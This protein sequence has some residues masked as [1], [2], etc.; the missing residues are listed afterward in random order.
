MGIKITLAGDQ[1]S[2]KSTVAKLL[3]EKL[4]ATYYSTG[5]YARAYATRMNMDINT[6]GDYTRAHPEID[7]E[8]DATL[9]PL[10][11]DTENN[12]VIDSRMA[13]H[14][15]RG[16][17]TVFLF[18]DRVESARRIFTAGRST[19]HFPTLEDA[20]A[21]VKDRRENEIARYSGLYGVD[22]YDPCHYALMVDTTHATP[23]QVA[24]CIVEAQKVWQQNHDVQLRYVCPATLLYPDDEA[25]GERMAE[26]AL[27]VERGEPLPPV[28]VYQK[29]GN[30][31]VVGGVETALVGAMFNMTHVPFVFV[32]TM[33]DDPT[34][35][36]IKMENLLS[37]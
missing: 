28:E 27:A 37:C 24:E 16:S 34:I 35:S 20:I 14:F 4:D 13:W 12:L 23:E 33:P 32:D 26:L 29:E 8:I 30:Y 1:G 7:Y 6:F 3:I 10:S 5:A 15:V 18:A 2:G 22:I 11:D 36:Y 17:F 19:E 21:A 25:S 9:A 31:Y